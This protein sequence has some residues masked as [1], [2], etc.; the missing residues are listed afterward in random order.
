MRNK[1]YLIKVQ[2][3]NSAGEPPLLWPCA[4]CDICVYVHDEEVRWEKFCCKTEGRE[5]NEE[6]IDESQFPVN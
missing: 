1:V 5:E 3:Y 2:D 6:K 4:L